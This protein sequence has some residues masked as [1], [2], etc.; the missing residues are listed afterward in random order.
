MNKRLNSTPVIYGLAIV[1]CVIL[2]LA[3][4]HAYFCPLLFLGFIPLFYQQD[5]LIEKGYPVWNILVF[6]LLTLFLWQFYGLF[7]LAKTG[8]LKLVL[9]SF[10]NSSLFLLPFLLRYLLSRRYHVLLANIGWMGSWIAIELLHL[11]WSFSFPVFNLGSF[12]ADW[13]VVI[14]WYEYTG[15]LGGSLWL[16]VFNASA[17]GGFQAWLRGKLEWRQTS[18]VFGGLL[19]PILLSAIIYFSFAEKDRT[20]D[21][22]VLHAATDCYNEKF[23]LPQDELIKQYI[24]L[25]E[26]EL[27]GEIDYVIWPETAIPN[28]QWLNTLGSLPAV[29]SIKQMMATYPNLH[30]ISGVNTYESIAKG[31][32]NNFPAEATYSKSLDETYLTYNTAFQVGPLGELVFRTKEQ[33]VPFEEFKVYPKVFGSIQHWIGTLSKKNYSH[34]SQ[35]QD[36]FYTKSGDFRVGTMICYETAFGQTGAEMVL[37]GANLLFLILNEGWYDHLQR[38]RQFLRHSIVRSIETRRSMVRSSNRGISAAISPRGNIIRMEKNKNPLAFNVKVSANKEITTY[39]RWGDWIGYLGV[40]ATVLA[41][42]GLVIK[43]P[44]I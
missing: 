1:S 7:W 37:K 34:R 27:S 4:S 44:S 29:S 26:R 5:L 19:V 30:F 15:L 41:L 8:W 16:L 13:P 2:C 14:Q 33:L 24:T 17:Y 43:P 36:V 20:V 18:L 42:S 25:T 3:I 32:P 9:I 39:C 11:H 23:E 28:G 10:C 21:V 40:L 38:A 22:L 31:K 6:P 12:L 35:N